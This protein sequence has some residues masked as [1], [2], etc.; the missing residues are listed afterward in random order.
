MYIFF[1]YILL[2]FMI[3]YIILYY[4]TI[5]SILLNII[6]I[7]V[8]VIIIYIQKY[9]QLFLQ[10]LIWLM[11][12][13]GQIGNCGTCHLHLSCSQLWWY[14]TQLRSSG[15]QLCLS[16]GVSKSVRTPRTFS[17]PAKLIA[18][19]RNKYLRA[20]IRSEKSLQSI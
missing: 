2:Y 13:S 6:Y 1:I 14:K 16:I 3:L 12:I 18:T 5:Y 15:C 17:Y 10:K 11:W 8:Y 19:Y 20:P 7:I 4:I 9:S